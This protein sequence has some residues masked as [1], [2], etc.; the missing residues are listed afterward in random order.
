MKCRDQ[1]ISMKIN[2]K[3]HF[4]WVNNRSLIRIKTQN[5]LCIS[6][7]LCKLDRDNLDDL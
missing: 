5:L 1:E 3:T 2:K 6:C 7:E 4:F